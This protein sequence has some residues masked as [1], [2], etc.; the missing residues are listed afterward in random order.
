M[1]QV[2]FKLKQHP[3]PHMMPPPS[4][5]PTKDGK[6]TK[7]GNEKDTKEGSKDEKSGKIPAVA[8]SG[9]VLGSAAEKPAAEKLATPPKVTPDGGDP[10]RAEIHEAPEGKKGC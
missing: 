1:R 8:T 6:E 10:E 2:L 5:L 3:P 9:D 4:P 7:D